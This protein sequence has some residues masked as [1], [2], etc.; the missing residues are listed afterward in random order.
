NYH[1]KKES[2]YASTALVAICIA[3]FLRSYFPVFLHLSH[4]IV[5]PFSRSRLRAEGVAGEKRVLGLDRTSFVGL[6]FIN[7]LAGRQLFVYTLVVSDRQVSWQ[8]FAMLISNN[9]GS[10][11]SQIKRPS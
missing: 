6:Y 5:D 11:D 4:H 7:F 10:Y 8:R 9:I 1:T 2:D 3:I